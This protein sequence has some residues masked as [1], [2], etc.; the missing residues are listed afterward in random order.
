MTTNSSNQVFSQIPLKPIKE[1][2][3][4][5]NRNQIENSKTES[6]NKNNNKPPSPVVEKEKNEN[7]NKTQAQHVSKKTNHESN[8]IKPI[9]TTQSPIE[10]KEKPTKN[11]EK[12]LQSLE[13]NKMDK[14]QK[15]PEATEEKGKIFYPPPLRQSTE[16]NPEYKKK[17]LEK[18]RSYL[19]RD[20]CGRCKLLGVFVCE[21][22]TDVRD[23]L[24]SRALHEGT[25][26][27]SPRRSKSIEGKNSLVDRDK[28]PE[29][30]R[31]PN[32]ANPTNKSNSFE[33]NQSIQQKINEVKKTEP[34]D[35]NHEIKKP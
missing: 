12:P 3:M 26:Y 23:S 29:K 7:V 20:Q 33:K 10:K 8:Q 19:I 13:K 18:Y 27:K 6:K 11:T 24:K 28:S 14:N 17:V 30:H 4:I 35:N 25:F 34:K 22:N 32:K 21:H 16:L 2:S 1:E 5:Q 15:K 9:Q 31:L